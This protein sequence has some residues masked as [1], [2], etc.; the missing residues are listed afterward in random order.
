MGAFLTGCSSKPSELAEITLYP[1][2]SEKE[3][4]IAQ[5][6]IANSSG[7]LSIVLQDGT[8]IS[9]NGDYKIVPISN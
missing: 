9:Y 8:L 1:E 3:V 6:Y 2:N 5:R 7:K 4:L